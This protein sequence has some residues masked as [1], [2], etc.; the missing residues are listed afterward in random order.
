M[1]KLTL[2]PSLALMQIS[3]VF[4]AL[5]CM[6][7]Y[8]DLFRFI[9][10][11]ESEDHH[12]SQDTEQAITSIPRDTLLQPQLTLS[13]LLPPHPCQPNHSPSL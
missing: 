9:T 11:V 8:L 1:R 5:V 7:M 6:C 13:L 3:P 4:Y 2:K 12:H 10:C